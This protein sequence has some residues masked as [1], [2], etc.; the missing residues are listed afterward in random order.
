MQFPIIEAER[1]KHGLSKND[2]AAKLGVSKRT[3]QNWQ[4]GK[5]VMPLSKLLALS[6]VFDCSIDYLL[7]LTDKRNPE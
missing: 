6:K 3:M 1:I 2:L 4:G 7:G 5:T